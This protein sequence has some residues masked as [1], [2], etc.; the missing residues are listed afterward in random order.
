[1]LIILAAAALVAV[2]FWGRS[3]GYDEG[4]EEGIH[5]GR[6]QMWESLRPGSNDRDASGKLEVFRWPG[7]QHCVREID[8]IARAREARKQ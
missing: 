2:Y 6:F 8:K 5:F 3:N 1:M 7:Y 4:M